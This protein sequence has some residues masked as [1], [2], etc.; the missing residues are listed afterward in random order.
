MNPLTVNLFVAQSRDGLQKPL[1]LDIQWWMLVLH[2]GLVALTLIATRMAMLQFF[3]FP[4]TSSFL[5]SLIVLMSFL[6]CV[7]M[8]MSHSSCCPSF[9]SLSPC[10]MTP[11]PHH[12]TLLLEGTISIYLCYLIVTNTITTIGSLYASYIVPLYSLYSRILSCSMMM[13][14][15]CYILS[16]MYCYSLH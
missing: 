2:P 9:P 15:F 4:L 12:S 1:L 13:Y 7:T 3:S 16:H 14:P 5:P 8:T 6:G 10:S 11:V